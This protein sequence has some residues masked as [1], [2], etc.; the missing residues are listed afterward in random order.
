MSKSVDGEITELAGPVEFEAKVLNNTVL[1]AA[2]RAALVD[3]EKKVSELNRVV[4]GAIRTA[5]ETQDKIGYIKRA[6]NGVPGNY[7]DLMKDA[8][9]IEKE[10]NDILRELNVDR[11][12]SSRN[13]PVPQTVASR[14]QYI[15]WGIYRTTSAPTKTQLDN[16]KIAKGEFAPLKDKLKQIVESELKQLEDNL[17]KANAPWT[18][19]RM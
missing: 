5:R 2:D 4:S 12:I 15:I 9:K 19:G 1:P 3:F 13:A 8:V 11:T 17:D 16:Y 14:V 6:L 10:L 7:V 18:P